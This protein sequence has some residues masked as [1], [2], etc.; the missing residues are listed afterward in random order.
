MDRLEQICTVASSV[1][2]T[3]CTAKVNELDDASGHKHDIVSL[4]ITMNHHVQVKVGHP[5]QNLVCVQSQDS[6]WQRTKPEA[7]E[8]IS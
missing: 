8:K 7:S 6:L 4:Q 3:A 1:I 5:F 2:E